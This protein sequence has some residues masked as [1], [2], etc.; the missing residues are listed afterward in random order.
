MKAPSAET[1]ETVHRESHGALPNQVIEV[2]QQ[3][4][5]RYMGGIAEHEPGEAYVETAF[6]TILFT[7]MEGSTNLTNSSAMR[8]MAVLRTHDQI[9]REAVHAT[10]ARRS[11]TP[12]TG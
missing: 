12:A 9:I 2:D 7:D 4:V 11:S 5:E 3:A 10:A 8:A 1:V 6:R